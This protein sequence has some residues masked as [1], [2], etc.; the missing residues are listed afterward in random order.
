MN[1]CN[2]YLVL[3]IKHIRFLFVFMHD[4]LLWFQMMMIE[5]EISYC[6]CSFD[7]NHGNPT[8]KFDG[9]R[10]QGRESELSSAC[11]TSTKCYLDLQW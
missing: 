2:T 11:V 10:R 9:T 7:T 6:I 8:S 4:F 1:G 3:D 5:H